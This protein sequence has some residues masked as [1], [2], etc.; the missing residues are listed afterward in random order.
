[1]IIA[2]KKI[3]FVHI[4]KTGGQSVTKYFLENLGEKPN[5]KNNK[6]GL[7]NNKK[8][9]RHGPHHFHHLL[10]K[11]YKELELIDSIYKYFK[12]SVVRNPY[13]RFISAYYFN[14]LQNDFSFKEVL[15]KLPFEDERSDLYRMFLPQTDYLMV[16]NKIQIDKLFYQE[17]LEEF[18]NFFNKKYKMSGSIYTNKSKNKIIDSKLKHD[19]IE[20]IN[21]IYYQDFLLLGY[22]FY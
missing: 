22:N 12:I 15:S 21:N 16:D 19:E 11:E 18:F 10:L 13:S 9:K 20:L 14:N 8:A 6:Y 3:L 17:N 7:I 1:M 4:P 2:E 5:L